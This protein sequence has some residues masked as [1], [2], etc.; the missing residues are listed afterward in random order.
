M[1]VNIYI[2]SNMNEPEQVDQAL[3]LGQGEYSGEEATDVLVSV[4]TVAC[5]YQSL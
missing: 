4:A 5:V 1:S 3:R 2:I